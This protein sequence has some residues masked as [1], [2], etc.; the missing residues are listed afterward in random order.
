MQEFKAKVH[1][2]KSEKVSAHEIKVLARE[3]KTLYNEYK[4]R[5]TLDFTTE[6]KNFFV[7]VSNKTNG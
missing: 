1:F 3:R 7:I 4:C 6:S 5:K 2:E